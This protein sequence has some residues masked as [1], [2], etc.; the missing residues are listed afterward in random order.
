MLYNASLD[1]NDDNA[2]GVLKLFVGG[3]NYLSMQSDIQQYFETYG[4][5]LNCSLSVDKNTNKSKG[6]AFVSIEDPDNEIKKKILTH[7]HE[8][9]G[10]IVDVKLAVDGKKR[11]EMLDA[12]KK[13][14]VGGLDPGVT[15]EDLKEFF[16]RYGPVREACV[17]FD[18]NRG[19]SRCFGFVTFEQKETVDSLV[20]KNNYSI[21]GKLVDVKQALPK[22]LQKTQ[23]VTCCSNVDALLNR[24]RK[25]NEEEEEINYMNY[26]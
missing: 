6:F 1:L 24:H 9:N 16:N 7:K 13:I 15:N 25:R 22:S 26:Y 20:K 14:F 8:I 18:N 21:K 5:V 3:L 17:L 10:K 19:V 11:E 12:T 2:E 4:H 23:N